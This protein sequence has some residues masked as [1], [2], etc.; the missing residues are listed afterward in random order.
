MLAIQVR[1]YRSAVPRVE[2]VLDPMVDVHPYAAKTIDNRPRPENKLH[3]THSEPSLVSIEDESAVAVQW[4]APVKICE[5]RV[6][7]SRECLSHSFPVIPGITWRSPFGSHSI[8]RDDIE[9][10]AQYQ[11]CT[12]GLRHALRQPCVPIQ[13]G[14]DSALA[15]WSIDRG[16]TQS[17]DLDHEQ[18]FPKFRLRVHLI[19]C[20]DKLAPAEDGHPQS[21][22]GVEWA[23]TISSAR[24]FLRWEFSLCSDLLECNHVRLAFLQPAEETLFSRADALYVPSSDSH[25]TSRYHFGAYPATGCRMTS[26]KIT[27]SE[28]HARNRVSLPPLL[29]AANGR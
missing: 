14:F 10:S 6:Q 1:D 21:V 5:F 13:L 15:S 12:S 25:C 28:F 17:V 16:E 7:Q 29:D 22:L 8:L 3:A 2:A 20:N 4:P 23:G 18:P 26:Q 24:E 9:V 27:L 11:L 19:G